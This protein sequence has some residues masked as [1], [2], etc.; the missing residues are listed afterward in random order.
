MNRNY[1]YLPGVSGSANV[2]PETQAYINWMEDKH[3]VMSVNFHGGAELTNFPWDTWDSQTRTHADDAWFRYICQ[4]YVD[5]C[6]AEDPTYMVGETAF[7]PGCGSV[8]EG[9][10]WYEITGSRQDYMDDVLLLL[11]FV[12]HNFHTVRDFLFVKQEDFLA[13]DFRNK[14]PHRA[15][16]ELVLGEVGRTDRQFLDDFLQQNIEVDQNHFRP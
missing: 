7:Q 9:G 4:N 2:Q 6:Q 1:P 10:D 14:E 16:G 11:V 15:V 12:H 8:T 13:D 5:Q 3:F